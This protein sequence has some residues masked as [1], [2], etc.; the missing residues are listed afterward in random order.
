MI[1]ETDRILLSA[2]QHDARQSFT[3]LGKRVGLTSPA[4]AD[5]VR[6]MEDIGLISGYTL[7]INRQRLGWE[8]T[9]MVRL[10]CPGEY[11]Q[12]VHRLSQELVEVLEC[13]HVTGEDCFMIKMI[14]RDMAHLEQVI[15]RFRGFGHSISSIVLSTNVEGKAIVPPPRAAHG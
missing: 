13:H 8:I 4:V 1:D 6:R 15:A 14:A 3:A 2:L 5:R 12:A 11:Y 10:T 9:A 7:K